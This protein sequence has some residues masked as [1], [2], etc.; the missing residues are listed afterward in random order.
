MKCPRRAAWSGLRTSSV[1]A[2][3]PTA[4]ARAP[5]DQWTSYNGSRRS[6]RR[7]SRLRRVPYETL[8]YEVADAVATIALDQPETRNALSDAL[9]D[10]LLA[11][12][13]GR[14][15]RRR[16]A[17][18]RAR[19]DARD[20]LLQRR[21]P[22]RASPPTMPLVDR[23]AANGRF[24]R[25]F[26]LIGELGKPV[27]CAAARARARRRARA[28]ARVRPRHRQRARDVR[29]AGDQRRPL[30]VHDRRADRPQ[31]RAQ[32]DDRAAA[33][34]RAH[35]RRRGAAAG[36][37]QP[38]R[39]AGRVRRGGRRL[40]GA[41]RREVAAAAEARQGRAVRAAGHGASARRSST[42]A[43]SSR[44]RSRREDAHEGI[45]AFLERR[46]PQWKGR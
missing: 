27:I 3:R 28:R 32:E 25:L 46:E 31:R 43:R 14:A 22:R 5:S 29:H 44:S 1:V 4:T 39:R 36:D 19:L 2:M 33:A 21:R 34:R 38:R 16:R 8:R 30:S 9:L 26:T 7:A 11:A 40:G 41:A 35:R 23:H 18:R 6:A 15:R 24:P 42:C 17:R 13:G 10:E 45:A 37:R 12:L 20:G